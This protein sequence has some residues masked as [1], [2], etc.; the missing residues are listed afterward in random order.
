MGFFKDIVKTG[1]LPQPNSFAE[2]I[3][4]EVATANVLLDHLEDKAADRLEGSVAPNPAWAT[5]LTDRVSPAS[6]EWSELQRR[7]ETRL[8]SAGL[9]PAAAAAA[10]ARVETAARSSAHDTAQDYWSSL[11]RTHADLV[12]DADK[13]VTHSP[14][15]S[16]LQGLMGGGGGQ[17]IA[18]I[19][20]SF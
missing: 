7:T 20:K 19:T 4:P 9:N 10:A 15:T 14:E 2:L 11:A 6:Q 12:A 18:N 16:F 13:I 1:L 17:G 5:A 3:F 8:I